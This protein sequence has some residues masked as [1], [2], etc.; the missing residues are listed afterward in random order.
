[1]AKGASKEHRTVRKAVEPLGY[2]TWTRPNGHLV[3]EWDGVIVTEFS[4]TASDHRSWRNSAGPLKR[5]A[6]AHGLRL[7]LPNP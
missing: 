3:V 2:T 1:M 5:H 7:N 6:K 4:G